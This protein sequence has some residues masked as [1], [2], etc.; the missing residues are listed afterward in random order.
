MT[1]TAAES[2]A[3]APKTKATPTAKAPKTGQPIKAGAKSTH[4]L[5]RGPFQIGV[6]TYGGTVLMGKARSAASGAGAR[7]QW[8]EPSQCAWADRGWVSST[9][10]H[11]FVNRDEFPF[12]WVTPILATCAHDSECIIDFEYAEGSAAMVFVEDFMQGGIVTWPRGF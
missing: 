11:I 7:G 12:A 8:L 2:R 4:L 9:S 6:G 3:A 1:G 10:I 5:C